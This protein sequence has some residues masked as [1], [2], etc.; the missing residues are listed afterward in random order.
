[1]RRRVLL[2]EDEDAVR[3]TLGLFMADVYDVEPVSTAAQALAVLRREPVAAVI[4]DHR[5]P[6]RSGLDTLPEIHSLRPGVPVIMMTGFGSEMLCASALRHGVK[7]YLPKPVNRRDLLAAV[8]RIVEGSS[9]V[10]VR[11][12]DT[13]PSD[14]PPEGM[15]RPGDTRIHRMNRTARPRAAERSIM[16]S[17]GHG[18]NC[19]PFEPICVL[20]VAGVRLYREGMA[21]NLG[22]REGFTVA[23]SAATR[24]ETLHFITAIQ[25]AVVVLDMAA[26]QSLDLVRAITGLDSRVKIIAFGVEENEPD[27]IACAEAGVDG[28]VSC[29]GSMD[30]LAATITSVIKGELICTPR[31]AA[32]LLRRVGAL[33]RSVSLSHVTGGL[34]SRECEILYLIDEGLSNKEIAVRLHIEVATVKNHVHNLLEKLHVSSRDEAASHLGVRSIP[35][36]HRLSTS[37]LSG[38]T[39]GSMPHRPL[40]LVT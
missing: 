39:A 1:M 28:Y 7:D 26:D 37:L 18:T 4:L 13:K 36:R 17:D 8:S 30:D 32:T 15:R 11:G 35:R 29:E 2:V 34:T 5:L 23:A 6:D 9:G 31:I 10:D 3:D 19:C 21:F 40:D 27:I 22:N 38:Q 16:P 14:N 20:V 25:P 33:A 12:S 24:V